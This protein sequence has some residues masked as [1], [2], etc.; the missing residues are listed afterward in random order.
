MNQEALDLV[1]ASP[2]IPTSHP[3]YQE[4]VKREIEI[5]GEVE[6]ACRAIKHSCV[7]ITG[8]NGKTTVTLL[9]THILNH[10]GKKAWALGNIGKPLTEAIDEIGETE[11]D[12]VFVLELSSFQLETLKSVFV[13]VG[14]ILNITPDH[15]D[16]YDSLES[17]AQAKIRLGR[18]I[19]PTGTFFVHQTC[20]L[21]FKNLLEAYHPRYYGCNSDCMLHTDKYC[22]WVE[23]QVTFDVPHSIRGKE[24]VD[25]DNMLAAYALCRELGVS[26]KQ[27][28]EGF[29][30]FEKPPHRIQFIKNVGG[31]NFYDDSKGTN[32][33]AVIKA[34]ERM[35]GDVILIAGGVDKGFPYT[36][37]IKA[38][39][40]KVK[41]I[42]AIGEAAQKIKNDLD[43]D[44]CV[45]IFSSMEH[46]VQ[47]AAK[48]A[49]ANGNVLLSPGCSSYD[50]FNDYAHRGHEFQRIV[51]TL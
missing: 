19:K 36:S 14:M 30:S 13:D 10:A 42:C 4:A 11:S 45:R 49:L 32:I 33:D 1:I 22:V 41:L 7:A 8:T 48:S 44:I 23:G 47:Y 34:V 3:C 29:E 9:V 40:G 38:F 26:E 35:P 37:W 18:N 28:V 25:L 39:D 27:F 51:H 2:G 43:S 21:P 31:M 15:L 46:A 17:Y 12:G 50:M 16:R 5:I 24:S 20:Q 6:L